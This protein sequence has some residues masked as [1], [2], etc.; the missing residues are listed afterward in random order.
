MDI[1]FKS[2]SV[3]KDHIGIAFSDSK[4]RLVGFAKKLDQL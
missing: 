1:Q 4:S 2:T 3:E